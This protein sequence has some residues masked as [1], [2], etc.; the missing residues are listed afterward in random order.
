MGCRDSSRFGQR[1]GVVTETAAEAIRALRDQFPLLAE[2]PEVLDRW[3]ELVDRCQVVG[4][5]AHDA[6]LAALVVV[7]EIQQLLT[8]NTADFPRSWGVEAAHPKQFVA[9]STE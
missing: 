6:R 1:S 7:H 2:T 8:F 3:F 5:R 9:S 4:K